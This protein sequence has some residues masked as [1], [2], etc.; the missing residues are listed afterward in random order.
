M[1]IIMQTNK[2]KAE[3]DII[4]IATFSMIWE[5][6]KNQFRT[7]SLLL[8][9]SLTN[10]TARWTSSFI[11]KEPLRGQR[12]CLHWNWHNASNNKNIHVDVTASVAMSEQK[13]SLVWTWSQLIWWVV[14]ICKSWQVEFFFII[15]ID[16]K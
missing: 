16:D 5:V 4:I 9:C 6:M 12:L 2:N 14:M 15:F 11:Y 13:C 7:T 8:F 1:L 10:C 3:M